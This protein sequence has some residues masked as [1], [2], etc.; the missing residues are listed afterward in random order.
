MGREIRKVAVIGA[1]V[2]GSGI[3]AH[4]ANAGVPCLL[5]DIVPREM[6]PEE[7]KLGLSLESPA[8]RNRMAAQSL[9]GAKKARPA[10]FFR[11]GLERLIT[12]GNLEDDLERLAEVDWIIEVVKEDLRIKRIVFGNIAKH[13]RPGT[14]V[15]SNTSGLPIKDMMEGF[16]EEFR[17][18]FFVT[19]FFNPVRYMRLLEIVAGED[20]DPQVLAD[21]VEFGRV[22]LGKGIVYGKDTPN[23][24]ANRIGIHGMMVAMK[25][26]KE[27]DLSC[28]E[29]DGILGSPMGRPK[30][31]AFRTADLVGLDTFV[32]VANNLY[33]G[34]LEDEARDLFQ[35]PDFL[36]ALIDKGWLGDKARQ[37]FYK[38]TRGADGK[39]DIAQYDWKT[40]EYIPRKKMEAP[41]LKAAKNQPTLAKKIAALVYA[42][43]PAGRY[44]WDVLKESLC[45]SARR[46]P[47][48]ADDV[49]NVDRGM[50]WGF[51]WDM[52][53]FEVWDAIGV[54]KS[55]EKMQAEGMDVP[56]LALAAAEAGGFYRW[57]DGVQQYFDAAGRGYLPVEQPGGVILLRSQK[58]RSKVVAKNASATLI[59]LD[60][61]VLCLEFH[62]KM[63]A[64]DDNIVALIH[65]GVGIMER[66]FEGMVL[67]NEAD[68]FSVGANLLMILMYARQKK[69]DALE[70]VVREFQRANQRLK[71][72]SKPTVAAPV[73]MALGGGCE[74]CLG[75]NAIQ[76]AAETYM[77]LV[78]VGVGLIPA[79]GGTKEVLRRL[80]GSLPKGT[81]TDTSLLVRRALE[82][83]GMAKVATSADEAMEIGFL[84]PADG[85]SLN[86]D[87]RIGDAKSAVLSMAARGFR[88]PLPNEDICLPGVGGY[89]TLVVGLDGWLKGG[90][91]TPHDFVVAKKLAWVLCGGNTS[92]FAPV[93]EQY[94]LDLELEAFMSLLGEKGTLD[95]MAHMLQTGKPLRN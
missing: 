72:S 2:M 50:R 33:E 94:L 70:S 26:M 4:L 91:I 41:S 31:A 83:I 40:G 51:G 74:V 45:Y 64:I 63:N 49:V 43:D 65:E 84:T 38:K 55:V 28:S 77:G 24:I 79:G 86:R 95:R 27:H 89:A 61:G 7:V 71:Y 30:S 11:K 12:V 69:W 59:D 66:D 13:R 1:G 53:P 14:P 37:G 62:S 58:D 18:H 34:V 76:A 9:E 92:A 5:L 16:D 60:D 54:K 67:A 68:H 44:A 19:H 52:G 8:V 46:I 81:G 32:H 47:E 29:V 10:A 6:T 36:Q 80:V 73:G 48:I 75:C 56:A 17:R 22:R 90:S 35:I 3:A 93:S 21:V 87:R 78:E 23:F 25:V 85:V 39:K 82:I 20:T 15:T 88:A 42:D 57:V